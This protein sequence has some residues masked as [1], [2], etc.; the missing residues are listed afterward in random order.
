MNNQKKVE[1]DIKKLELL[2]SYWINHNKQH[3]R[4]NETWLHKI[5]NMGL[6]KVASELRR[7]IALSEEAN[8][9]IE[10]AN[11]KLK[12]DYVSKTKKNT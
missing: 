11:K 1:P 9:H 2:M 10:L 8:E 12:E 6:K 5:E 7:F 3:I 4:D